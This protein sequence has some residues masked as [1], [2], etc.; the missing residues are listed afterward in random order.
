M[1]SAGCKWISVQFIASVHELTE[2]RNAKFRKIIPD[3]TYYSE[4]ARVPL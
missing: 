4:P 3:R 1:S 2:K